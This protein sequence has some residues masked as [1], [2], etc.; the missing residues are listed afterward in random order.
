[1][2][3][4]S[5]SLQELSHPSP[6]SG[7]GGGNLPWRSPK[8]GWEVTGKTMWKNLRRSCLSRGDSDRL[9]EVIKHISNF[10][11]IALESAPAHAGKI[12]FGASLSGEG[13]KVNRELFTNTRV[14]AAIFGGGSGFRYPS[15][16]WL[17]RAVGGCCSHV[18]SLF[19]PWTGAG[20]DCQ[21]NG[22]SSDDFYARTWLR[23]E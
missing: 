15:G 11:I 5:G 21:N 17:L 4:E 2:G 14:L 16:F 6:E 1:M 22:K 23:P 20:D 7:C 10:E 19:S 13:E 18:P 9:G 3:I 12:L 8:L